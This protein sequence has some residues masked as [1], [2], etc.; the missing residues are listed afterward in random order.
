MKKLEILIVIG[1]GLSLLLAK[2][3]YASTEATLSKS[4]AYAI[5][6]L[7]SLTLG[8][9]IYLFWVIFQPERF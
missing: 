6:I 9:S 7:I 3:I 4:T 8:L 5:G 2:P 1:M